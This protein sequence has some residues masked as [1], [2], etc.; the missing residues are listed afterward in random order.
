MAPPIAMMMYYLHP[1]T[2]YRNVTLPHRDWWR[3]KRVSYQVRN[4]FCRTIF[5][6]SNLH[7][8]NMAGR[9]SNPR[10][11]PWAGSPV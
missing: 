3:K 8:F 2:F 1:D 9:T 6:R 11:H 4:G 7:I 5:F 10:E